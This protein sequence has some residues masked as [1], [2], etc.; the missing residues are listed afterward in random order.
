LKI[1]QGQSASVYRKRTDNTM[2]KRKKY[3]STNNDLQIMNIKLKIEK[4]ELHKELGVNSDA[5]ER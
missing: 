5:L 3:K 2:A 1:P 4:H